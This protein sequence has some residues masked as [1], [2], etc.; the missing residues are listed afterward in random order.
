MMTGF[1]IIFFWVARMIMF[2]MHFAGDVPFGT[3]YINGLVRDK[4]GKKMSKTANN[5]VDPLE[6]VEKYGA[7]AL[8]FTLTALASA[9]ND[10]KLDIER[11]EGY[12]KFVNK[13]WNASRFVLMN[14]ED[15]EVAKAYTFGELPLASRW[16]LSRLQD[17]KG[18]VHLSLGEYR[19][20]QAANTLYHFVWH[21]FCDWYIELSKNALYDEARAPESRRVLL[22]VLDA[23]LRLLHPMM[24]FV[25]EEIWQRLPLENKAP[26]LMVALFPEPGTGTRETESETEM[27]LLQ[28]LIT[29]IRTIRATYEVEPKRRID[30]T[31]AT[32]D[33]A[34]RGFATRHQ[35]L[36]KDLARVETL[37]VVAKAEDVPGTIQQ[38]AGPFDL[39]IPMA[40]LFDM[41]AEK[42][43]LV[44]ERAKAVAELEALRKKL[45]NAQFVERAKPE[46]V[47]QN[48][49][50][51]TELE[52]LLAKIDTTLREL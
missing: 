47:A 37:T 12:G 27:E 1:D 23:I 29:E 49:E 15:K 25:T 21:D 48:R 28:Q 50:R 42:A 31:I 40:G 46:V 30:V 14:V 9:G 17:V 6:M 7:D 5:S 26:S 19:F 32:A 39:R 34:H 52:T 24:P 10:P 18:S 2:G 8:R 16:I 43:R 13:L 22:D 3:V 51:V 36:I 45:S 41:E 38:A 33:E 44:K 35:A 11:L 20:D 4:H